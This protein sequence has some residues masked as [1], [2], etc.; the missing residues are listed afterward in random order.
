MSSNE[1][2]RVLIVDDSATA[3]AA[4]RAA[5]ALDKYVVVAGEAV[6]GEEA[7][8]LV[9]RLRPDIVTMD[10]Y[11]TG[12]AGIDVA[13]AIMEE[14]PTPILIV[15]AFHPT[16]P[17][18]AFKAVAAGALDVCGKPPAPV[19]PEYRREQKRLVR[20]VRTLARV[21]VV[22][23]HPA[24]ARAGTPAGFP[25]ADSQPRRRDLIAVGAST[26]GPPI[27]RDLLR[28]LP[29]EFPLPVVVVQHMTTGFGE[30]Y[31]QWL[32]AE[33]ERKVVYVCDRATLAP[34]T[35][36]VADDNR[37]LQVVKGRLLVCSDEAAINFQRPS[38]DLFFSSVARE[39]GA[40]AV[41]IL[42]TGMGSDGAD[43]LFALR[44]AGALTIAQSPETCAV[45]SMPNSAIRQDAVALVLRPGAIAE[46]IVS[47]QNGAR[48][49][50]EPTRIP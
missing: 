25:R 8:R 46:A 9:Q 3:R 41:A 47:L 37:H 30:S 16:D 19:N 40:R 45:D 20:L 24:R 23:R 5:L 17:G 27:V 11:L 12:T 13:R 26:G 1:T 48:S 15:T 42:L 22:R 14:C 4:I 38:I 28:A 18:L 10:L 7:L 6:S 2:V 31:S 35:V 34:S 39:L 36:F 32:A 33:T 44:E 29:A 43:G 21:P 49:P 50:V